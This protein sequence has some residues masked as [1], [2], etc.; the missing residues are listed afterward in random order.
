MESKVSETGSVTYTDW[1]ECYLE[2]IKHC[3]ICQSDKSELHISGVKDWAFASNSG[4]WIFYKC[5]DCESLYLNPR[6][7]EASISRAYGK[8]YTHKAAQETRGNNSV[9]FINKLRN[10]YL[11]HG[12]GI[13]STHR[14][15]LKSKCWLK[16]LDYFLYYKF[17]LELLAHAPRGTLLDV[18]CGSGEFLVMAK[19]MGYTVYGIEIDPQALSEAKARELD[20]KLGSYRDINNLKTKFDY[21]VCSHVLEHVYDP[22]DF[23][24]TVVKVAKPTTKLILAWPNPNSIV[25]KWF[26]KYWRGLEAPRHIC[27]PSAESVINIMTEIGWSN[28][29][30]CK[31]PIH[32]FGPSIIMRYGKQGFFTK[33]INKFL[34]MFTK[35][36]KMKGN[37]DINEIIFTR[38]AEINL[39]KRASDQ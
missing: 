33:V 20:V 35:C 10:E 26:G 38:N 17:P 30:I 23:L 3:P 2:Q 5:M 12:F 39:A 31:S 14:L 32:T 29:Y 7:T 24:H 9:G 28:F 13:T 6:P 15:Y 4:N 19:K 34:F 11:F 16:F 25:L 36:I 21:I 1:P 22:V 18:G 27:L 37:Q 8:Y